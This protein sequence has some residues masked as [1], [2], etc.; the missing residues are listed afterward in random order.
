VSRG[1]AVLSPNYRGLHRLRPHVPPRARPRMGRRP[2]SP[3]PSP[4][5]GR[6]RATTVS[7]RRA[8]P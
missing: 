1:W 8:P 4:V 3:T 7:T 2:T 6:S 5:C